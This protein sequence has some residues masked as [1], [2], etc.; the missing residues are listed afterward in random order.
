MRRSWQRVF[1]NSPVVMTIPLFTE[2]PVRRSPPCFRIR[3]M[4]VVLPVERRVW[5]RSNSVCTK[6]RPAALGTRL[7]L[8]AEPR[9]HNAEPHPHQTPTGLR[10]E[11]W[12]SLLLGQN[13]WTRVALSTLGTSPGRGALPY[14]LGEYAGKVALIGE[15]RHQSNFTQGLIRV[16]HQVFGPLHPLCHQP[17]VRRTPDR[18]PEGLTKMTA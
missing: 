10:F 9:P 18:L 7:L 8:Y 16:E 14:T 13:G 4:F 5:R 3:R 1:L 2:A 17:L 11:I 15:A 6:R 12:Q